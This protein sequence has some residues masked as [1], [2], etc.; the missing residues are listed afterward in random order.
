MP[1]PKPTAI[2]RYFERT[3]ETPGSLAKAMGRHHWTIARALTG[4]RNVSFELAEDVERATE[5]AVT[6]IDFIASCLAA[7]RQDRAA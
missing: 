5:G 6:A 2:E 4:Q 7:R 1:K 3:G